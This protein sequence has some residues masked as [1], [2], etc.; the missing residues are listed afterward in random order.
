MSNF[1]GLRA[2]SGRKKKET[3]GSLGSI[4]AVI[5]RHDSKDIYKTVLFYEINKKKLKR[6]T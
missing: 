3:G 2:N 4:P 5:Y 1:S 6:G